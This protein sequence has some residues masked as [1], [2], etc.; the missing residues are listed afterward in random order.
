MTKKVKQLV[1]RHPM[2]GT[3]FTTIESENDFFLTI[4]KYRLTTNR[5][6]S[7]EEVS[8]WIEKNNWELMATFCSI[9]AEETTRAILNENKN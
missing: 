5:F 1:K 2:E 8:E 6:G 4:G 3:P 9:V 7:L